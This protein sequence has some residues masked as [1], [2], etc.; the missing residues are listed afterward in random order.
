MLESREIKGIIIINK[1]RME[2]IIDKIMHKKTRN[3]LIV[4]GVV[5][6]NHRENIPEREN[7]KYYR[8]LIHQYMFLKCMTK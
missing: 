4:S 7:V 2:I 1:V 3:K 6:H 5:M 8:K